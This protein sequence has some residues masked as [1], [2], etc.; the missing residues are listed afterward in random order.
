MSHPRPPYSLCDDDPGAQAWARAV[1]SPQ[2][3]DLS[4]RELQQLRRAVCF[5]MATES[6]ESASPA[7]LGGV[8][9]ARFAHAVARHRLEICLAP[10]VESLSVPDEAVRV[11]RSRA[12]HSRMSAMAVAAGSIE[13]STALQDAGLRLLIIK[14]CALAV[15]TTGDFAA[16][17]AGDID[18]LVHPDDVEAAARALERIGFTRRPYTCTRNFDSRPWRYARWATYEFSLWR[19]LLGIDLHWYLTNVRSALPTF[20]DLWQRREYVTVK[21]SPLPTLGLADALDH[22][23]AH[24]LKEEWRWIRSLVDIDRLARQLPVGGPTRLLDSLAVQLTAPVALDATRSRY[25]VPLATN[26]AD[27]AA[28][29]RRTADRA[30][31]LFEREILDRWTPGPAWRFHGQQTRLASNPS[32]WARHIAGWLLPPS[33]FTDPR[34]GNTLPFG[35]SIATRLRRVVA[36]LTGAVG[37]GSTKSQGG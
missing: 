26:R 12:R 33:A 37:N 20:D 16:R 10:H 14:G 15:Q 34:T 5:A 21:S 24:A 19:G 36:R 27:D 28:R 11:I 13:V 8:D 22:S 23:C 17:G 9:A 31:R 25:L 32:D 35:T 3:S 30:Q 2:P 4:D 7:D 18:A 1:T 29:V 6:A